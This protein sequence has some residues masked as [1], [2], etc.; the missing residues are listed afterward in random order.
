MYCEPGDFVIL[1]K[2]SINIIKEFEE[3]NTGKITW[4]VH[5]N[6]YTQGSNNLYIHQ[7]ITGCYGNGRGTMDISVDHIDRN[8][9]N[10]C[11]DNLRIAT[12]EEQQD[13]TKSADGERRARS[14][15]AKPLPEGLTNDMMKKYVIYYKECYNK[16][17]DLYREFFKVECHPKL[18]KPWISS[19][20][21]KVS[22]LDKLKSA[23][24]MVDSLNADITQNESNTNDNILTV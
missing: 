22:L 9:L 6:G 24:D 4:H 17:K 13:N 11:Y 21:N 20:S 16:E 5:P 23:N 8:K 1:C 3:K 19:K 15:S 18:T 7:I 14:S 2:K 12:R 10:N